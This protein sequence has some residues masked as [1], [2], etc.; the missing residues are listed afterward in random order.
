[1]ALSK[2]F[3]KSKPV[4][5]VGF[6]FAPEGDGPCEC[7]S[8]AG[9]FSDWKPTP[10][11]KLKDGSFTLTMDLETG[12]TYEFRYLVDGRTW[13]NDPDADSY[14]WNEFAGEENSVLDL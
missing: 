6:K 1:M 7:V 2:R 10:M 13:M 12:R 3:L 5:K 14:Q 4:C 8:V 9:E 11:R